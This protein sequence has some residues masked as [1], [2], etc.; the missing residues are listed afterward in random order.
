MSEYDAYDASTYIGYLKRKN[1]GFKIVGGEEDN[2]IIK[3]RD[4]LLKEL[5]GGLKQNKLNISRLPEYFSAL[6]GKYI[7]NI[8]QGS[9][10]NDAIIARQRT[11]KITEKTI[12]GGFNLYGDKVKNMLEINAPILYKKFEKNFKV[13]GGISKDANGIVKYQS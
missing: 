4:H 11:K 8:M 1:G 5:L 13:V 9:S 7:R 6:E 12:K 2:R 3:N 10:N